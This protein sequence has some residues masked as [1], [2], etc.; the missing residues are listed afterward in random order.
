[1][2]RI[3]DSK[4]DFVDLFESSCQTLIGRTYEDCTDAERFQALASIVAAKS[5][6]IGVKP[7]S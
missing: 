6:A 5:R 2:Q 1:M 4:E 7:M 3:F